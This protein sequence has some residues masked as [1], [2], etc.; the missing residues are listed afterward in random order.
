MNAS[1]QRVDYYT[2]YPHYV[3]NVSVGASERGIIGSEVVRIGSE[4]VID[5]S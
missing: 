1:L 3:R 2:T 5:T 4:V